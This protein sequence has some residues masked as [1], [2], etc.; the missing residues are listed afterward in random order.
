MR[1]PLVRC[2]AHCDQVIIATNV[3]HET[4][5]AGLSLDA[6]AKASGFQ[7]AEVSEYAFDVP[8]LEFKTTAHPEIERDAGSIDRV[9]DQPIFQ[10]LRRDAQCSGGL[11]DGEESC[12]RGDGLDEIL[13]P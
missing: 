7:I 10:P 5:Q 3:R 12:H 9:V 4:G 13:K 2:L 1:L 6:W 8:R 11:L